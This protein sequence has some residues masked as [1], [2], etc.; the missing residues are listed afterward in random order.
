MKELSDK[1]V[2]VVRSAESILLQVPEAESGRPVLSGGW[3]R[4]QVLGHLIDSASNN[5]QRFVRAALQTS[6]DFPGYD[7]DGCVRVQAVEEGDWTL[8]V[9]LW[10]GYN[11]YLAHV[12]AHLPVSKLETLCRIGLD[13]PVTLRFLAEDY[14]RHL[15]HHLGQIGATTSL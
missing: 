4:K 7:Q 12:I 14:L 6:L 5:H 1:L 10:A 11:R 2:R 8:L 9:S 13:E 3:S 15:L